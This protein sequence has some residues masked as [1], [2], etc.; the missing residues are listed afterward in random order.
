MTE[1]LIDA[2]EAVV[3]T[4][5]HGETYGLSIAEQLE[6]CRSAARVLEDALAAH[7]AEATA[8]NG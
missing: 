2:C 3:Q 7:Q 4:A 5:L 6:A 1:Q 8:D